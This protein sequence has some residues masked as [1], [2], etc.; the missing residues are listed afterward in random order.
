IHFKP[1]NL[2]DLAIGKNKYTDLQLLGSSYISTLFIQLVFLDQY[3][4]SRQYLRLYPDSL[5]RQSFS[6][7]RA[8]LKLWSDCFVA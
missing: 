8:R 7:V 3:S 5:D 6:Q 4:G 1:D 2:V